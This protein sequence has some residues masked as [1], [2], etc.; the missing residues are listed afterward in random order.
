MTRSAADTVV[1]AMPLHIS[2]REAV[3]RVVRGPLPK[4]YPESLVLPCSQCAMSLAVGPRSVAHLQGEKSARLLCPICL[5]Q[6][7]AAT[8]AS[9]ETIETLN[10]GNPA[11]AFEDES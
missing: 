10:L 1:L 4:I 8:D 7:M 11:A 2:D 3:R 9:A 5:A 6:L